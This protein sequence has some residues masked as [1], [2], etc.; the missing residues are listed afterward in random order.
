VPRID[1]L[2][3]HYDYAE[4]HSVHVPVMPAAAVRAVRAATPG[5]MPLVRLLF[6]LRS[7]PAL[8]A[9]GRGLPAEKD[10]PLLEQMIEFGFVP[11]ADE[12]DELVLGFVGQPWK[13]TGGTM[14]RLTSAAQWAAFDE[15][16]YLKAVMDF[17]AAAD[18]AGSTLVTETRVRATDPRSRR[19]FAR[20]WLVVRFGSGAVR[21]SWLRA[22]RARAGAGPGSGPRRGRGASPRRGPGRTAG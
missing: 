2:L 10:R 1:D 7:G 21:R 15:P 4:R 8:V 16:G 3:P 6:A 12:P 5:E 19:R 9:R 13:P 18:S 11:L 14:P 17:R 20:Y 22:A